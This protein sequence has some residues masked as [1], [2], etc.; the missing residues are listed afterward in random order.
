[1]SST[2]NELAPMLPEPII[3][4]RKAACACSCNIDFGDPCASC[5]KQRW[6]PVFCEQLEDVEFL[7]EIDESCFPPPVNLASNLLSAVG[8]EIK[9]RINGTSALG[10]KEVARRYAI[11]EGCEYFHAKSKRC[12]QCGCF[13]KWKTAL[14]S[15][16]C[17]IGKW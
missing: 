1:M 3:R 8:S 13:L 6:G 4:T 2:N 5:P 15:Q 10:S 7:E 14:R 17:P 11:C 16:H 12:T 9:A